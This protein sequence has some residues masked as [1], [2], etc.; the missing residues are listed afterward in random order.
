MA[1]TDTTTSLRALPA[2]LVTGAA[3]AVVA[4]I[5]LGVIMQVRDADPKMMR[6]SR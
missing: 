6:A 4:G 3:A 5:P 1:T 2:N